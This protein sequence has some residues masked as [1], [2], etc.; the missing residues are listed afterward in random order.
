MCV[1]RALGAHVKVTVGDPAPPHREPEEGHGPSP[2]LPALPPGT[3]GSSAQGSVLVQG[4][5]KINVRRVSVRSYACVSLGFYCPI[6]M[7]F[8]PSHRDGTS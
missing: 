8:S 6:R 4:L 7:M 5:H 3:R 2:F 1:S